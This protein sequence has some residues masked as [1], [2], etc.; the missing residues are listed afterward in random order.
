MCVI[1]HMTYVGKPNTDCDEHVH[2]QV[3]EENRAR[4]SYYRKKY[5]LRGDINLCCHNLLNIAC[6]VNCVKS[7]NIHTYLFSTNIH[8]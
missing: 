8:M 3:Y 4:S 1:I 6:Q 2:T 5:Q 7:T